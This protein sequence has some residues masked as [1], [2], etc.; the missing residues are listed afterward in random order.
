M[1]ESVYA[2]AVAYKLRLNVGKC[3][4]IFL[5]SAA[6]RNIADLILP[7]QLINGDSISWTEQVKILFVSFI[8][9]LSWLTHSKN[10][11]MKTSHMS[12]T[13]QRFGSALDSLTRKRIFQASILPHVLFCLPVWGNLN[14]SQRYVLDYYL[15]CTRLIMRN[16]KASFNT[17]TYNFT[18][19]NLFNL[20]FYDLTL[21]LFSIFYI[22][23]KLTFI[24]M[25][26]YFL[27]FRC[28][29]QGKL[30]VENL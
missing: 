9:L 5:S 15:L 26:I 20:I 2:W 30:K 16:P 7:S 12:G 6:R 17:G 24:Y 22:G 1:L 18:G 19:I 8:S 23:M 4:A 29:K 25:P 21:L 3:Y 27:I 14:I 13:L 11:S 28:I 10:D